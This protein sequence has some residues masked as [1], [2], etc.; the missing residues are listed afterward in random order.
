MNTRVCEVKRAIALVG[1]VMFSCCVAGMAGAAESGRMTGA[2]HY[3]IPEWFKESFLEIAD[4]ATEADEAGKHLLLFFHLDDCPFCDRM[5]AENFT[6]GDNAEFM[7]DN[8]DVIALNVRGDREVVMDETTTLPEK[9]LSALLKVR[10]TPAILFVSAENEVVLRI[11]GYRDQQSFRTAL[12]YIQSGAYRQESF[13]AYN[14]RSGEAVYQFRPHEAFLDHKDLSELSM[15]PL[16]VVFEDNRCNACDEVHD[17]LFSR[18][19]VKS[20]LSSLNVVRVD[21][22]SDEKIIDP[23]GRE[24][25]PQEWY[26]SLG[27]TFRPAVVLFGEGEELARI[28]SRFSSWYFKGYVGWVA[29]E[30]YKTMSRREYFRK[31]REET[32]AAGR[33]VNI[34]D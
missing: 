33:D 6:D 24:I 9:Q 5:L 2:S 17:N 27:L 20:A 18:E 31:L 8:F 3:E 23:T 19:D 16:A 10:T 32:L 11:D 26:Q 13:S 21:S 1:A 15:E 29:G 12:N 30:H 4:D 22:L 34:I 25:S 28:D 14:Q 7:K